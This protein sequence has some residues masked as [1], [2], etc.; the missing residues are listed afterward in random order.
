MYEVVR[1]FVFVLVYEVVL[2]FVVVFGC[3][4]SFLFVLWYSVSK[5][6]SAIVGL[7]C[8]RVP[9]YQRQISQRTYLRQREDDDVA[10]NP[11]I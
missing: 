10:E 3:V 2:V 8:V 1:A 9:E 7:A 6:M 5:S 11:R 4:R